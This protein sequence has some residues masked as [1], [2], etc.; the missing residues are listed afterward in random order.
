MDSQSHG[1][2]LTHPL[3]R[4]SQ[5]LILL[6]L[7]G[8]LSMPYGNVTDPVPTPKPGPGPTDP[9]PRP[10]DPKPEPPLP[11]PPSPLPTPTPPP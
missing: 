7:A 1:R 8:W 4:T 2:H 11:G 3:S 9:V 6:L 5:G 10:P